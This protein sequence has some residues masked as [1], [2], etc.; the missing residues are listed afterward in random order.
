MYFSWKYLA[1]IE[2][3]KGHAFVFWQ[4]RCHWNKIAALHHFCLLYVVLCGEFLNSSA[5]ILR[6][7]AGSVMIIMFSWLT[8]RS[9]HRRRNVSFKKYVDFVLY[10]QE[11]NGIP[12]RVSVYEP[13]HEKTCLISAFVVC[14][15]DR[16]IPLV[17]I[18]KISSLYLASVAAQAG[19]GSLSLTWSQTPKN[20]FSRDVGHILAVSWK[21]GP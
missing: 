18:S 6:R 10:E 19:F 9:R 3:W 21:K 20:S 15:L 1:L 8:C 14:C 5:M 2:C 11:S 13:R 16:I 4:L 12:S 17:S 7:D